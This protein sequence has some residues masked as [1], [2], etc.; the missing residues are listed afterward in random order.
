MEAFI[1]KAEGNVTHV[2]RVHLIAQI[3][4]EREKIEYDADVLD[5]P[6]TFTTWGT[7]RPT[8]PA[9]RSTTRR[10]PQS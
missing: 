2:K 6:R 4:A 5:S 1:A 7:T 9:G 8:T 3:L 10:H